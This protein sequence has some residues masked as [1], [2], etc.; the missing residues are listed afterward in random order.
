M[1]EFFKLSKQSG[2][3]IGN[4]QFEYVSTQVGGVGAPKYFQVPFQGK[5][6]LGTRDHV[7]EN[8]KSC[9][10]GSITELFYKSE[11]QKAAENPIELWFRVETRRYKK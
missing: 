2:E 5:D 1:D 9:L 10:E 4:D 8:R 7:T 3:K 11:V 6:P